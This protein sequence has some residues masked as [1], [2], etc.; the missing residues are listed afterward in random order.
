[1]KLMR[2]TR[3]QVMVFGAISLFILVSFTALVFNVGHRIGLY[4]TGSS[5]PAYEVHPNSYEP[6][7]SM[8]GAPVA[9]NVIHTSADHASRLILPVIAPATY[10]R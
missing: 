9:H 5:D 2:D 8:E 7:T 6:V 10:A 3:G 4:V 1:M